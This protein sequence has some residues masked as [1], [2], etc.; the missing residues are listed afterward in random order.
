MLD[1]LWSDPLSE[2]NPDSVSVDEFLDFLSVDWKPNPS[3]GCSVCYGYSAVK[4]FL[5][6]NNLVCIIRAHEVQ[7][8]GYFQHF[9]PAIIESKIHNTSVYSMHRRS[10]QSPT[11]HESH[12]KNV[13][14][15]PPNNIPTVLTIFSAPNYCDRYGNK[16]SILRIGNTLDEFTLLQYENVEHPKTR[17]FEN[18]MENHIA[19]V[20]AICP[21]MPTSF[22]EFV[23]LALEIGPE[24]NVLS[25]DEQ[26][27]L[28]H[29]QDAQPPQFS[30]NTSG[31]ST[32]TPQRIKKSRTNSL[33]AIN[34]VERQQSI[35]DLHI[36]PV[37]N[38][39]CD[40]PKR[41]ASVGSN[42]GDDKNRNL[43]IQANLRSVWQRFA[44]SKYSDA[45]AS[46]AINE[47]HPDKL[48]KIMENIENVGGTFLVKSK[49]RLFQVE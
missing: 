32:L 38:K 24:E 26:P 20:I 44:S 19:T 30:N 18:P 23:R 37:T 47:L 13:Q 27:M 15:F 14:Y 39:L 16:G 40:K 22:R 3:R 4:Q 9:N 49:E 12:A 21:Y 1:I 45:Q 42:P 35:D 28:L 36:S 48:Q 7:E 5:N 10:V 11:S 17:K 41:R 31:M 8:L 25:E 2:S 29:P 34:V 33:R 46:D 6:N 43:N